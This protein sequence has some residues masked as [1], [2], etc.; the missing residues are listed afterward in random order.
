MSSGVGESSRGIGIACLLEILNFGRMARL[1]IPTACAS[2][3]EIEFVGTEQNPQ[4]LV[5]K[6]EKKLHQVWKASR[7]SV[8]CTYIA[9]A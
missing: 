3:G 9:S 7:R 1:E 2:Q 8:A 4:Q 5:K 6:R